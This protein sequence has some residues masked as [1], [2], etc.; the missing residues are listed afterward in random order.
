VD[1][2]SFLSQR[3]RQLC[4]QAAAAED[5]EAQEILAALRAA[6]RKHAELMRKMAAESLDSSSAR[7]A[8]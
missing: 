5:G 4:S 6:L 7:A 1:D 3:I 2:L 8:D